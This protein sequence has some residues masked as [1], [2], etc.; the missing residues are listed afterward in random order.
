MKL[1][2]IYIQFLNK[3]GVPQQ[4]RSFD[5]LEL[6][7]STTVKFRYDAAKNTLRFSER[8]I[9]LPDHFW[10]NNSLGSDYQN[11]YNIN[12]IAGVNGSGKTTA[13]R[14][15]MEMLECFYS[16]AE[17]EDT[18]DNHKEYGNRALMLIERNGEEFLLDYSPSSMKEPVSI[19]HDESLKKGIRVFSC[20][21]KKD[22]IQHLTK[23]RNEI[24]SALLS[25][26]V[27]YITNTLSQYDYERDKVG[28]SRRRYRFVYN[29]S[30][31]GMIGSDISEYFLYEIYKQVKYIF[32]VSQFERRSKLQE[33]IHELTMPKTLKLHLRIDVFQSA[34]KGFLSPFASEIEK[35]F[36]SSVKHSR[37][38]SLLSMLCVASYAE[39]LSLRGGFDL[40]SQLSNQNKE[41]SDGESH[42]EQP[43]LEQW[44]NCIEYAFCSFIMKLKLNEHK[45]RITCLS[46]LDDERLISGSEDNTLKV[47]D[48]SSGKC[49]ITFN[50]HKAKITCLAVCSKRCIVSGSADG[51]LIVWDASNGNKKQVLSKSKEAVTCIAKISDKKI[52]SGYAD[53]T[54]RV[55]NLEEGSCQESKEQKREVTFVAC[56]PGGRIVSSSVDR[57]LQFWD[58][59][60]NTKK[61]NRQS[62]EIT[63]M[64]TLSSGHVFCGLVGGSFQIWD[65][66]TCEYFTAPKGHGASITCIAEIDGNH[67]VTGSHD[68]CLR[69]WDISDIHSIKCVQIYKQHSSGITCVAYIGQ[70]QIVS[71]SK[72]RTIRIW[73][74]E[75]GD[76]IQT[77]A[78]HQDEITSLTV[79]HDGRIASGDKSGDLL[80]SI[81]KRDC[82][83]EY[84]TSNDMVRFAIW[85]RGACAEYLEFI[86]NSPDLFS[87]FSRTADNT[88]QISLSD[89]NKS[90]DLSHAMVCFLQKYREQSYSAYTIDF[91]WGLSSGE[92]NMLRIFSNLF[93]LLTYDRPDDRRIYNL[94]EWGTGR[95]ETECD[96][97]L[98]FLDE[99]DLTL[100][101]EW[102]RRFIS[103]L[104]SYI[105][106]I[107]PASCV[108]DI[109]LMLSTH[110]PLM[111]GD[112]PGENITYLPGNMRNENAQHYRSIS[113]PALTQTFGQNIH[114][115]LMNSFFLNRTIGQF[116]YQKI[117]DIADELE[118]LNR[119]Q[120][121]AEDPVKLHEWQEKCQQY[122]CIIECIG[123]P[124][125]RNKLMN[126]YNACFKP[127]NN[128]MDIQQ[129][130]MQIQEL[131]EAASEKD[132][133]SMLSELDK[134]LNTFRHKGGK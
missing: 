128:Q 51:S 72:D 76:T 58:I 21:G 67:I 31:G 98:L 126:M 10:T 99:A 111:L 11:I 64:S 94:P 70:N 123:D 121:N 87:L 102:Q 18:D 120:K 110:S 61:L 122:K 71:A 93:H 13:I 124:I 45:K 2:Y 38:S 15:V 36:Q 112:I 39:E 19:P 50:K 85:L 96:T 47:W 97:L 60:D 55:W 89:M 41:G 12:V 106:S 17:A 3:K 129:K 16:L 68:T 59:S 26:K 82:H 80:I 66:S 30:Q 40:I 48:V 29:A 6:N 43:S 56:L 108:K 62:T 32:D 14:C 25:T 117:I 101:P 20:Y 109:Q 27:A 118:A 5:E 100:H 84:M 77:I 95:M 37:L 88:Y 49:L 28:Q 42:Q 86:K 91:D 8:R 127:G 114:T 22:F 44:L 34:L 130:L 119:A 75:N 53:G 57:T 24:A 33:R 73:N 1:L 90:P 23:E 104:T 92:E 65:A 83:S 125:I 103:I 54:L 133:E 74:C 63:C 9:P 69:V 78:E 115:I 107:F 46:V 132:R 4:Y 113:E 105:P 7:F 134:V 79:L 35:N 116:A 131:G 81:T 52:V